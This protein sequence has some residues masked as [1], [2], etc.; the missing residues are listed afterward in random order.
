MCPATGSKCDLDSD[1]CGASNDKCY[2]GHCEYGCVIT[3]YFVRLGSTWSAGMS[4][5]DTGLL[6]VEE[7]LA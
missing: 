4:A 6:G 7:D 5:H 2:S 1:C 3:I